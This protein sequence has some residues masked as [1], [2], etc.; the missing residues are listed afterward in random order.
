MV[1][2]DNPDQASNLLESLREFKPNYADWSTQY[3][4]WNRAWSHNY[5]HY[6]EEGKGKDH[7]RR[8]RR[9]TA[10]G[11]SREDKSAQ[12]EVKSKVPEP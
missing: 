5:P 1:D 10:Q 9:T 3:K 12:S 11:H 8:S 2:V 7:Q 6:N 4:Y